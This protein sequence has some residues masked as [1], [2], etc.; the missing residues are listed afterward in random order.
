[1]K[2]I[3]GDHPKFK[4]LM[5]EKERLERLIAEMDKQPQPSLPDNYT[6]EEFQAYLD[7]LDEQMAPIRA[8]HAV[9]GKLHNLGWDNLDD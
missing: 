8:Y 1:M 6:D 5:A 2:L 9:I 7:A 4:P 3:N